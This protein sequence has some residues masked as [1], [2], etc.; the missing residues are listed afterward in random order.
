MGDGAE[1]D[2]VSAEVDGRV[3][4]VQEVLEVRRPKTCAGAGELV[5]DYELARK[6]GKVDMNRKSGEKKQQSGSPAQCFFLCG[7]VGHRA[8]ERRKNRRVE[9]RGAVRPV[10]VQES[11]LPTNKTWREPQCYESG[12][13]GHLSMRCPSKALFSEGRG[14]GNKTTMG[15]EAVLFTA[16]VWSTGRRSQT[17]CWI[18]NAGA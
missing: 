18:Q 3:T 13:L 10:G 15:G 2:G 1:G 5:D 11:Q 12:K 17:L 16:Q 7:Q 8:F 9:E 6:T 14:A 4:T